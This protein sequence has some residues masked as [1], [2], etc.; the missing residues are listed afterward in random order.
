MRLLNATTCRF[1]EYA[2][3]DIPGYAFLSHT[4]EEGEVRFHDMRPRAPPEIWRA[5]LGREEVEKCC[6]Q[7]LA[8]YIQFIR[9]DTCY[10]DKSSSEELLV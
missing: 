4:W 3:R 8:V 7:T 10:F 5:K 2:G 9:V 6:L 1:H